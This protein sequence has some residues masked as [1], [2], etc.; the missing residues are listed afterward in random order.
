MT[1]QQISGKNIFTD[2]NKIIYYDFI[3]K[4]NYIINKEDTTKLYV[5]KNR[6]A[7]ILLATVLSAD[8]ILPWSAAIALGVVL[9]ITIELTFRRTFFSKLRTTTISKKA[10]EHSLSSSIINSNEKGKTILKTILYLAFSILIMLNAY[11][12]QVSIPVFIISGILCVGGLYFSII[13]ILCL[14]KMK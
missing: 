8:L 4:K 3:T 5:Y 13:H 7:F 2:K 14:L 11:L 6:F 12:Q 9:C 10:E 1:S